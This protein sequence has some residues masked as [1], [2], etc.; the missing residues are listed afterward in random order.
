MN[1]SE[2]RLWDKHLILLLLFFLLSFPVFSQT[3]NPATEKLIEQFRSLAQNSPSELAYIQTSKGIYEAGED[4]WFKVWLLDAQ[5]FTP[6]VRSK[7]LYLQVIN[8]ETNQAFWQE[9]YEITNGFADGHVFLP[10]SLSEGNYLLAAYTQHSFFNDSTE[11]KA[12]RRIQVRKDMSSRPDVL[13][14]SK[15]GEA[16]Q[17]NTFPEGGNL[18]AGLKSKLAFKA[19]Y[20]DGNPVDVAGTLFEDNNPLL[21]FKSIHA[22]MGSLDFTPLSGKRYH[23]RLSEPA[24]DST[25][26]LP[27]TY[28]EGI[29]MCLTGR[30][31]ESLEF[32]IQQSPGLKENSVFLRAQIRGMV[33]CMATGT[34]N[35][36]LKI[37]I[38]LEKFPCQGIAE[39][40]L[41]DESLT[42]VAERLVY[43]DPDKKLYIET[44]LNKQ[45]YETREKAKLKITVKDQDGQPIAANLGISVYDK[46]YQNTLDPENILT[47]YYLSTQLKGKIYDPAWYFDDKNNQEAALDVLLLTQGWSRYVWSEP[48]LSEPGNL[49]QPVIFDEVKGEFD[50]TKRPKKTL[51]APRLVKAFNPGI[52]GTVDLIVVDSTGL[53]TVTPEFLKTWQGGYVYLKPLGDKL[54]ISLTD[55]FQTISQI[56]TTKAITYPLPNKSDT[57][58]V[59]PDYPLVVGPGNDIKLNGVT[60]IGKKINLFRDKYMGRLDSIAKLNINTDYVDFHG[61]LNCQFHTDPSKDKHRKPIEGE[62]LFRYV[63]K[64]DDFFTLRGEGEG[65]FSQVEYLEYHYPNYTE[66]QL[67]R[68]NNLTRVKAYYV[69]RQFYQPNYDQITENYFTPD[70]RNT[71]LWAPSVITNEKGEATLEFFCSDINTLFVGKIEGVSNAGMLGFKDFEFRVLKTQSF[72]P[73]KLDK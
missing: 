7:T 51:T 57:A 8:E 3:D 43:V 53:F 33:Y 38:P 56:R 1:G 42:P 39:F 28:A 13:I 60:V 18:I 30:E 52:N 70:S 37:K 65:T 16:I 25:F 36:E 2:P 66:E 34:L 22:G 4:L 46:L 31:K 71:L 12:L 73:N 6:S 35:N 61:A 21:E 41:F 32:T 11:L 29:S 9:K 15:K 23:I 44:K 24:T 68:T 26:F 63:G 45:K 72:K 54:S 14:R 50:A 64:G 27:E 55:P 17:F 49:K 58:K 5:W 20:I 67:L 47:H 69:K 59:E 10:D 40:T 62:K 19:V 48:A